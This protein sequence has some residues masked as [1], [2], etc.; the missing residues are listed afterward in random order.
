MLLDKTDLSVAIQIV[1]E[2]LF[3]G[4][5]QKTCIVQRLL[6]LFFCVFQFFVFFGIVKI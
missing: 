2:R 3:F 4:V 1:I 5:A 6:F